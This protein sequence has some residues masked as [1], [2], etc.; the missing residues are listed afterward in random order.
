M[1]PVG[2]AQQAFLYSSAWFRRCRL[3]SERVTALCAAS[4]F[5]NST[6]SSGEVGLR[7]EVVGLA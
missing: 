3:S 4:V 7:L 5:S 1:E 2:P 6:K